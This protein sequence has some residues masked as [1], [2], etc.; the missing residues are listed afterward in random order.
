[1]NHIVNAM[2]A[3]AVLITGCQ[4]EGTSV[5]PRGGTIV[6]DDGR[7]TLEIPAGALDQAVDIT[8]DE[9]ECEQP[10]A[11]GPCYEVGPVG[12]PLLYPGTVTYEL[13][14]DALQTVDVAGLEVLTEREEDW[15]PLADRQVDM[16]SDSVSASAVYLSSYAVVTMD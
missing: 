4:E 7:F 14:A 6:S 16:G 2:L 12:M 8:V 11:V 10:T 3:A 15:R 1:M 13:D 5:G 9:V